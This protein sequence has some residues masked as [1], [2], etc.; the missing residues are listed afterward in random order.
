MG[1][2]FRL[3]RNIVCHAWHPSTGGPRWIRPEVQVRA[4]C[5]NVVK[6]IKLFVSR[7]VASA[8]RK[9]TTL[10]LSSC[11]QTLVC[12]SADARSQRCRHFAGRVRVYACRHVRQQQQLGNGKDRS[13][14]SA[15]HP[16]SQGSGKQI[17]LSVDSPIT[18]RR[19]NN[20]HVV[21]GIINRHVMLTLVLRHTFILHLA[22]QIRAS[23]TI[24][25]HEPNK[26]P[27][28]TCSS[29][30]FVAGARGGLQPQRSDTRCSGLQ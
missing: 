10:Q 4:C 24:E 11:H 5:A 17:I 30:S 7:K 20:V 12:G 18:T 6:F 22:S 23:G 15:Q 1:L 14:R 8:F 29:V 2:L 26:P 9:N 3:P 16:Q 27:V 13:H 25:P 19:P 21:A 28:W